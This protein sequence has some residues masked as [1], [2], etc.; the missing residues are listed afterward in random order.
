MFETFFL[1]SSSP[2]ITRGHCKERTQCF[3]EGELMLVAESDV[4]Q[5]VM[6]FKIGIC[7]FRCDRY[8][9]FVVATHLS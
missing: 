8:S 4:E 7:E 9:V 3:I 2:I 5:N 6:E 1:S